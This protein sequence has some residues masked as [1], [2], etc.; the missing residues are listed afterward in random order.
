MPDYYEYRHV[1]GFEETNLV[2]NVYFTNHLKWQGRCRELFLRDHAPGVL[3]ALSQG[4]CLITA[5]CACDYL[6]ELVPFD[7]VIVRMRLGSQ[8]QNRLV[9]RFE[10]WRIGPSGE[11][12]VARGEQHVVSMERQGEQTV[13]IPLPV[14]LTEA[15]KKFASP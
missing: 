6:Q 4:L 3:A 2:G 12:L 1:V 7:E 15:L 11:E 5:R 9:M 13:P 14:E 8:G 10:Y